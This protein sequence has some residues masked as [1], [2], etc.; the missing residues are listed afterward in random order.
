MKE[1]LIIKT[2]ESEKINNL[3][4]QN[5]TDYEIVYQDTITSPKDLTEEEL[6]KELAK[7][8][9]ERKRI[10]LAHSYLTSL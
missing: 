10:E 5:N 3:L 1:L 9:E 6:K 4:D 7:R 8:Q 2:S